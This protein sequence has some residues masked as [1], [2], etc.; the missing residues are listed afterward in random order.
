MS[1]DGRLLETDEGAARILVLN[2]PRVRNALDTALCAALLEA[3]ARAEAAPGVRAIILTGCDGAFCSGADTR[4]FPDPLGARR[5]DFAR[6][7]H[8]LAELQTRL[9]VCPKPL[10]AACDGPAIGVGASLAMC[11]DLAVAS[12]G[13]RLG[14]P[15][16]RH[17]ILPAM[18]LAALH[19]CLPPK[20]AFRLIAL[21][22]L[23]SA[24]AAHAYGIVSHLTEDGEALGTALE[25][26]GRLARI[27]AG[28]YWRGK[29]LFAETRDTSFD[30][31]LSLGVRATLAAR[32]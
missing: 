6:R 16:F 24:E 7:T 32:R 10:V 5:S 1:G 4:E 30:E 15:E 14:F 28:L 25:L 13:L 12:R 29:A 21:G 3:L 11:C 22:E 19:R 9:S 26:A 31:A 23:L 17:G 18:V 2:R 8:L 20:P 27:D